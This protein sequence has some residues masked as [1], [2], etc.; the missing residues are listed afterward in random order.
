MYME[1][2]TFSGEYSLSGVNVYSSLKVVHVPFV[3]EW[4]PQTLSVL[5]FSPHPWRGAR[6]R[7]V[8]EFPVLL[9]P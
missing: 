9:C 2:S 7:D 5:P 8:S 6:L 3:I 1:Y 4:E